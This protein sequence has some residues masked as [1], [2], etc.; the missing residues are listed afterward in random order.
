MYNNN[1]K[2]YF[3]LKQQMYTFLAFRS[4]KFVDF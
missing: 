2:I 4:K 3:K 1:I